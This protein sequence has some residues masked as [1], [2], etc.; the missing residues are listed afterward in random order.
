[1]DNSTDVEILDKQESFRGW[2]RL[3][4]Y[5]LRH[6]LH[7]GGWGKPIHRELLERG[8]AV[9]VLPYDPVHDTV[10]LIE[11]FRV[12]AY[13]GG[14]PAWLIEAVAG[15]VEPDET[16]EDVARREAIEEANCVLT[17]LAFAGKHYVSPG[18][19]SEHCHVFIGRCDSTGL[20]G[21]HG[22]ADE[23]EDIRVF[24]APFAE[25]KA[26]REAGRI[27][28]GPAVIALLWLELQRDELRRRWR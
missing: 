6:R 24:V 19:T 11:Q 15:I 13:V 21:V 16:P 5:R 7:A 26:M 22:L 18:G 28:A 10:V 12:G 1:M 23:G 20:G 3:N 17:D 25:A 2:F 8:H 27:L 9:A 14:D 4:T